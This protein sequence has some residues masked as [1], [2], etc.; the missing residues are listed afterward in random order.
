VRRAVVLAVAA[1]LLSGCG[2]DR[3]AGSDDRVEEAASEL[4]DVPLREDEAPDALEPSEEGTGPIASLRGVLPPRSAFPNLPPIPGS[5][6]RAFEGGYQVLYV[7]A[8]GGPGPAS[9]ASSVIRFGSSDRAGAFLAYLREVQV[10]AGRGPE[11]VEVSVSDLG[12]EA[13]GWHLEEPFGESSTVV[14]TSGDLVLTVALGGRAGSAA[15]ERAAAL[16][17]TIDRRLAT[18]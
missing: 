10:G 5:I 6:R 18:S 9:A 4:E 11:R 14:W 15:P 13:F 3:E 7:R 12:E 8:E 2:G 1:V 16:A 17:R